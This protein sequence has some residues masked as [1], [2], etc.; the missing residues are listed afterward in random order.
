MANQWNAQIATQ[1]VVFRGTSA[2]R[3]HQANPAFPKG[4]IITG[5]VYGLNVVG[6]VSGSFGV[7]IIGNIGGSTYIVAG[8]TAISAAGVYVLYPVGYTSTGANTGIP[9]SSPGLGDM[10]RLDQYIP[11]EV[12]AFQSG[13]ATAGISANCTVSAAVR[14]G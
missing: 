8:V 9:S 1:T 10:N 7:H 3:V 14:F 2:V 5:A 13:V 6:G 4:R 11:P 12:V